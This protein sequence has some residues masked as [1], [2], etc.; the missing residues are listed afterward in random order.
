MNKGVSHSLPD[1]KKPP[2]I[3]VVCG[4]SFE[5][6][7]K[8]R[9]PHL[10][11][12]WPLLIGLMISRFILFLTVIPLAN[13]LGLPPQLASLVTV[14][15]GLPGIVVILII[16]PIFVSRLKHEVIFAQRLER[17]ASSSKLF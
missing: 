14:L 16:I 12:F 4:I 6:I 5:T 13:I 8:F 11:L 9:G 10:G 17:T 15:K 7:E 3:E 2:V 1:Y